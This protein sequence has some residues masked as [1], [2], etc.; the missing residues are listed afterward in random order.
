MAFAFNQSNLY[1]YSRLAGTTLKNTYFPSLRQGISETRWFE[2]LEIQ[3]GKY[4]VA[5]HHNIPG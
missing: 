1:H 3:L 5:L 2:R 4:Y